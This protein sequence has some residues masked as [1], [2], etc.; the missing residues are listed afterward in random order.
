VGRTTKFSLTFATPQDPSAIDKPPYN[1]Y[2]FV[3]NTGHDIHLIGEEPLPS[4]VNSADTYRDAEGFP[5]ALLVPMDWINPLECQRIEI[6][7]PRFTNWRLSMGTDFT[8]WYLHYN[9]PYVPPTPTPPPPP[10]TG[11]VKAYIAGSYLAST[12]TACYWVDNADTR[13]D[14]FNTANAKANSIFVSGSDVYVAGHFTNVAFNQAASYW[15]NGSMTTLYSDVS[16]KGIAEASAIFVSGSDVYVS[17][18]I[19][20]GTKSVGYWKN[21][22]W[23]SLDT[24]TASNATD[25]FVSGTDV[26][27]SGSYMSGVKNLACFWKNGVRTNLYTTDYS[28]ASSITVAG[29][30]VYLAGYFYNGLVNACYWKN[31]AASVTTLNSSVA[32]ATDIALWGSTVYVSGYYNN[33]TG[34]QA[35][36]YWMDGAIVDLSLGLGASA[37][38]MASS[39]AVA[40]SDVYVA[41]YVDEGIQSACY[42]KNGTRVD[43][44]TS[45]YSGASSVFLAY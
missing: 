32:F 30:D 40:G 2:L 42:W 22:Q 24:T 36:C 37:T 39:I 5:W 26:Y 18:Y 14:L 20:S 7:Y 21:G 8:D 35:A 1:P 31:N 12:E 44:F 19:T 45:G 9:D 16:G 28:E 6:P 41:G 13:T 34:N 38:S 33:T 29:S 17:G 11:P 15:K 23:V 3:Y 43:L 4:S 10:P 27:V 25:I